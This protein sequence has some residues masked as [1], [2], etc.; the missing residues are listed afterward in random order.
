M[1]QEAT[2]MKGQ[3][4]YHST[5]GVGMIEKAFLLKKSVDL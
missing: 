1:L 5:K 3:S 4:V 2:Q